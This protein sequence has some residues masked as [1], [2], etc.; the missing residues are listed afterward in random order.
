MATVIRF[1][2]HGTKK[3]PFFRIVV[4]DHHSPRDGKFIEKLGTFDPV[5]GLGSL[6]VSR[7]RIQYWMSAGAQLSDSVK[8]RLKLKFKEWESGATPATPASSSEVAAPKKKVADKKKSAA[9]KEA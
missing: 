5:K 1:A 4:Q 6:V 9:P 7:E 3:K 2:R 8:N